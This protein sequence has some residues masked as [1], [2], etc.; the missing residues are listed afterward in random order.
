MCAILNLILNYIF[1][2]IFGYQAAAYT[3]FFCYLFFCI[4]HYLFYKKVCKELLGRIQIYDIKFIVVLSIG[5]ILGGFAIMAVNSFLW[6]KYML[7]GIAIVMAVVKRD[8]I[9]NYL[10]KVLQDNR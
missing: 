1:I 10:K 7:I 3:T 2:N 4:I 5:V 9:I 8:T 6:L